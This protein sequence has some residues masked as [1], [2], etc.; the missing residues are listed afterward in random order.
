MLSHHFLKAPRQSRAF[1]TEVR[2]RDAAAMKE[3]FLDNYCDESQADPAQGLAVGAVS[4]GGDGSVTNATRAPIGGVATHRSVCANRARRVSRSVA[5][6]VVFILGHTSIVAT[7][8]A[9]Q[10]PCVP[11]GPDR[12]TTA[13]HAATADSAGTAERAVPNPHARVDRHNDGAR[14]RLHKRPAA[15]C[16]Y[17]RPYNPDCDDETSKDPDDDD[18][19]T[20]DVNDDTEVA[21]TLWIQDLVRY[22]TS[23]E[24][25]S[26]PASTEYPSSPFPTYQRLRC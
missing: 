17:A 1:R 23:V 25:E 2:G 20:N 21:S 5:M 10:E 16:K 6:I 8:L 11:V 4:L 3:T 9:E 12:A 19:T 7:V 26:A 18:D 24:A 14:L 22:L 15:R 13:D